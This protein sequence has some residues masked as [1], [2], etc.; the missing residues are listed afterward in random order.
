MHERTAHEH[1]RVLEESIAGLFSS[2][3]YSVTRNVDCVGRSG[4]RYEVDVRAE[5]R[6]VLLPRTIVVECKNWAQPVDQQVVARCALMR[7]D[8]GVAQAILACPAGAGPA[9]RSA[10]AAHGVTIWDGADLAERLGAQLLEEL[11]RRSG[12]ATTVGL[13]RRVGGEPAARVV[14]TRARGLRGTLT[15]RVTDIGDAWLGV[16]ELEIELVTPRGR[17]GAPAATRQWTTFEAVTGRALGAA[18]EPTPVEEV[19]LDAPQL[20]HAVGAAAIG[21]RIAGSVARL[22]D[23]T[24]PAA[25]ARHLERLGADLIPEAVV[26]LT[27]LAHRTWVFPVTLGLVRGRDAE[28]IVVVDGTTGRLDPALGDLLTSRVAGIGAPLGW[29]AVLLDRA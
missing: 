8:L 17:R 7:D 15:E 29:A 25:R 28:R 5:E 20:P 26:E 6:D 2:H 23:L 21:G 3:G 16:H 1:G 22:A 4:A 11:T 12:V 9:A 14:R 18:S 27:V 10:A 19:E 24:Q 13:S